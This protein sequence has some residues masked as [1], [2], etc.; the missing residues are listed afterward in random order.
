LVNNTLDKNNN[1]S[2]NRL[3]NKD[4]RLQH[5]SIYYMMEENDQKNASYNIREL[6]TASG[7]ATMGGICVLNSFSLWQM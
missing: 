5:R 7:V 1:N 6:R 4:D 3:L 2:F